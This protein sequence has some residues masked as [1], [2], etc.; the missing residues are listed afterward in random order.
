MIVDGPRS[1]EAVVVTGGAEHATC[2]PALAALIAFA[3]TARSTRAMIE[4]ARALGCDDDEEAGAV[5]DDLV[6]DGLLVR[7]SGD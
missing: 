7:R 3:A 1:D 5:L 2:S 4:Q 6:N